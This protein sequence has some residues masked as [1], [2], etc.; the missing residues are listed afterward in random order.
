[1][2]NAAHGKPC[3]LHAPA[4]L[5]ADVIATE[6]APRRALVF[7][8]LEGNDICVQ[9]A[10]VVRQSGQVG[11]VAREFTSHVAGHWCGLPGIARQATGVCGL[12]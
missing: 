7:H 4:R 5:D 11:R 3:R 9:L 6:Y 2:G 1:M 12:G 8:F 10:R